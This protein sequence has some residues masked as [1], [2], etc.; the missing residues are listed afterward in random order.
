ME[1]KKLKELESKIKSYLKKKTPEYFEGVQL[2]AAHPAV[3]QNVVITMEQRWWVG[4]MHEKLIYE[5]E[6][7][8]QVIKYSGRSAVLN[9]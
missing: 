6:K 8:I 3:R 9:A 7:I 5:L 1:E 2:Y 4:V